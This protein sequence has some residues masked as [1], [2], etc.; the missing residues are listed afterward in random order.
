MI[1]AVYMRTFD[2]ITHS[3]RKRNKIDNRTHLAFKLIST[4]EFISI[5]RSS[6][7]EKNNIQNI[8]SVKNT[9]FSLSMCK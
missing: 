4:C 8:Q 1:A 9:F 7:G 6:I 5:D 3:K 2:S